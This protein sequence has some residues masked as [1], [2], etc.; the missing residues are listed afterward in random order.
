MGGVIAIRVA[1]ARPDLVTHLILAA[2]S[3]GMDVTGLG[4][5]DWRPFVRSDHPALPGWFLD[6]REDLTERLSE[7]RMPVLLLWG[8]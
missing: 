1:L 6:D 8:E 7:L 2:T 4:A 5:E 3:G